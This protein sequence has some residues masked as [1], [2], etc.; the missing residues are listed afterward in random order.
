ML[1]LVLFISITQQHETTNKQSNHQIT[2]TIHHHKW[3]E[4][5]VLSDSEYSYWRPLDKLVKEGYIRMEDAIVAFKWA[6]LGK[7][8]SNTP[9]GASINHVM[10][11]ESWSDPSNMLNPRLSWEAGANIRRDKSYLG[12]HG[13]R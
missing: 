6:L 8:G 2:K 13:K 10:G 3:K 5:Y 9:M 11:W 7:R 1:A 12:S 4:G